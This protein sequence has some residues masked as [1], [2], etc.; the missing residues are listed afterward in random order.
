MT[1]FRIGPFSAAL[2]LAHQLAG[3]AFAPYVAWYR[4]SVAAAGLRCTAAMRPVGLP[5]FVLPGRFQ[6]RHSWHGL[7]GPGLLGLVSRVHARPHSFHLWGF[8][9]LAH[10]FRAYYLM[11]QVSGIV[12]KRD[13]DVVAVRSASLAY[14]FSSLKPYSLDWHLMPGLGNDCLGVSTGLRS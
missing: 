6:C 8:F 4:A 2:R 9:P 1:S 11:P 7:A 10:L 12:V 5:H 14:F 3:A 13:E